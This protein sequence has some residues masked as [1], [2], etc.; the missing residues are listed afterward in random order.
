MGGLSARNL[1]RFVIFAL[2]C[3]TLR[4]YFRIRMDKT[5]LG[6]TGERFAHTGI[7]I[8]NV[9]AQA[10]G[11]THLFMQFLLPARVAHRTNL[12]LRQKCVAPEQ[13]LINFI[14]AELSSQPIK[15]LN[16]PV[17]TYQR[18]WLVKS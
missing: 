14:Y 2:I 4:I 11:A 6:L 16:S 8:I 17:R 7:H 10:L 13:L 9:T 1:L 18:F 5:C 3:S 12:V 15:K